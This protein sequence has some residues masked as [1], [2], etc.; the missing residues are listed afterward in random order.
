MSHRAF[1]RV[2]LAT[3]ALLIAA[4]ACNMP[5]SSNPSTDQP[6]DAV[7][8]AAAQTLEAL[9]TDV[10][11]LPETSTP[12]AAIPT[13]TAQPGEVN[14]S[15][16]P[17]PQ[18]GA[19]ATSAP[20][21]NA[22]NTPVPTP[23]DSAG[24][25]SDV[26][27][28]DGTV[29]PAGTQFTKTWRLR[30]NGTCTWSADYD[31]VFVSGDA[32]SAPASQKLGVSVS[33]GAS[34]DISV[35]MKAPAQ[36]GEYRGNWQLRNAAGVLF[37]TGEKDLPFYVDVKVASTT[38]QSGGYNFTT[39]YCDAEW[40]GGST[41]LPCPGKDGSSNGFVL[42]KD[43][44]FLETG[45]Q[46]NEPALITNPPFTNG[47]VIQAKFPAYTVKDG[48][49]F[50]SI[51]G[52][53][54]KAAGCSVIFGLAYQREDGTVVS[55][56]TWNESYDNAYTKVDVDLSSLAGKTVRFILSVT[57]RGGGEGDRAEWLSPRIK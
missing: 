25:I 55:L 15:A 57:A 36:G 5:T 46:D 39:H 48:E 20:Q 16:T 19:T 17:V 28:P 42:F 7:G 11:Q 18:G 22:S 51:V 14:P 23:C 4:L 9:Q 13:S 34:V 1:P 50:V 47:G 40:T 30:N 12:G 3:L 29:M 32:M 54:F 43:N 21:A 44:P 33:P 53:E 24:F 56:G 37:G 38:P 45:Y 52:C 2:F 10:A 49:H 31:V 8:T 27:I 35:V 6:S 26:S 41:A